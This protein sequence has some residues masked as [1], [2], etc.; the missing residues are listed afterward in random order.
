M[1]HQSS[2]IIDNID[3]TKLKF[4]VNGNVV[5]SIT[6]ENYDLTTGKPKNNID[7]NSNID[8]FFINTLVENLYEN[9]NINDSLIY[10]Y[11]QLLEVDILRDMQVT[12][13][14]TI[15]AVFVYEGASM[16]NMFG[17]YMYTVDDLGNKQLL[18]ND[19]NASNSEGYYYDPTVIFPYILSED[20]DNNTLQQGNSRRLKGNLPNGNFSNIYIG[21]FLIPHGWFAF[22]NSSPIDNT[23]IFYST[24]DFNTQYKE[25]D[26]ITANEKIY[27][28]FFKAQSNQGHE[29]LLVGFEDIFV[30]GVYDLDYNDC[31]VGF[32]ISE[33]RNIVDY[34]KYCKIEV[35]LDLESSPMKNNII[36]IDDDGE[37]IKLDKDV[38][39]VSK[40][41][42]HIFE[43]HMI[44]TN[45]T[46]RDNLYNIYQASNTNYKLL[47]NKVNE[48]GTYKLIFGYKFRPNDLTQIFG[49]KENNK[50]DN[51]HNN[52]L[53]KY[54]YLYESKYNRNNSY[55]LNE[56]KKIIIK[57]LN[58]DTYTEKYKLYRESDDNE[59][60]HLSDIIDKP[61]KLAT[62]KFRI[63]GNGLMDCING[64]TTIPSHNKQIYKIYSTNNDSASLTINIKMDDHPTNF[65]ID[66]KTFVRYIS[67]KVNSELL[68]IDLGNLDLYQEVDNSLV[69]NNDINLSNIDISGIV[70]TTGNIKDLINVFKADSGAYYRIVTINNIMKF[71]CIRL[72]NVKNNPTLVYLD[73]NQYIGWNDKY[74]I[75]D[76]TYLNKQRLYKVDTFSSV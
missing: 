25:S 15:D 24:V 20:N 71:Y 18:A 29:L 44:F 34:D 35:D 39:N 10:K 31:V 55:L 9:K 46:N 65:M 52:N 60:I 61:C 7:Q 64:K 12:N 16:Q 76:C 17:Y 33:V 21:L 32:E 38:Y 28:I 72:P 74:N 11:P 58:D 45:Q 41:E 43:R 70:Y 42:T 40:T 51:E 47:I 53:I 73:D 22:K 69:L 59:I 2:K 3:F 19:E 57:I 13:E 1:S 48:F 75:L 6:S 26:Y 66:K 63:T 68:V 27:S 30:E 56:Y 4:L 5:D 37:Y 50:D 14:T 49:N 36:F 54:V 23:A 8:S 62:N 67:F